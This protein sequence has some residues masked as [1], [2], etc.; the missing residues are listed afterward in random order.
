MEKTK[1]GEKMPRAARLFVENAC[2][3][4]VTRSVSEDAIFLESSDYE[5]YLRLAHKYKLKYGCLIYG[6]CLMPNHVH[7]VMEFPK[8]R[9]SMSKFMHCL[10][11]TY[12]MIFNG[13]YNRNGH[14][15]QNRYK[16]FVV[17][18][19]DYF[20]NLISYV[21]FNPVRANIVQR[22]EDYSWSSYRGRVLGKEDI[23][24]DELRGQF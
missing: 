19:D 5:L 22:P 16:D 14:L 10:N 6:Y 23:I 1:K 18:K 4:M 11:Q 9:T 13:K 17:L 24:L 8:G 7:L 12:A 3:H 20:I 15:W 21:E 2:Y